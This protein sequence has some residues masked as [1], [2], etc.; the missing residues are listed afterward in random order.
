MNFC[1]EGTTSF[2][3]SSLTCIRAPSSS[4]NTR[5][6]WCRS[7]V[8]SK[9]SK[10]R[11]NFS[12]IALLLLFPSSVRVC[13]IGLKFESKYAAFAVRKFDRRMSCVGLDSIAGIAVSVGRVNK[14]V[15]RYETLFSRKM[16]PNAGRRF[17]SASVCKV[18]SVVLTRSTRIAS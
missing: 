3:A 16:D 18:L 12:L 1:N 4:C 13:I 17:E 7:V 9:R 15:T 2:T 6:S 11:V 14:W 8:S 5:A 10:N